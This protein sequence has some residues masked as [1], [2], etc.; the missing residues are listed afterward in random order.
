MD[1]DL[2]F[3]PRVPEDDVEIPGVGTVR[4]RGLTRAEAVMVSE[5]KGAAATER[6]TLALGLVDPV[7]TEAE[8]G[9]WQKAS[10]AGELQKVSLRIA[11]LSGMM[12]DSAKDAVRNFRDESES[13]I[14]LL[15]S[16]ETVD[17]GGTTPDIT[18]QR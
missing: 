16:A 4:V 3:K 5:T 6:K 8:A 9:Q 7:L 1:K 13:G 10:T 15:P 11:E 14:R 2:L 12:P 18:Y 17:D